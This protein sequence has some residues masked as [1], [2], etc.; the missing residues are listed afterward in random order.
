[1]EQLEDDLRK[2]KLK[3]IREI[4]LLNGLGL[5]EDIEYKMLCYHHGQI[6]L[7][8]LNAQKNCVSLYVGNIDKINGSRKRF[9]MG[10]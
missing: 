5:T 7:F 3:E 9:N 10:A 6:S 1:V 8:H 2:T 4:I